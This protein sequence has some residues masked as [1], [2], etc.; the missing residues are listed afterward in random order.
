MKI[1]IVTISYNQRKYLQ[2]CIDS[3]LSQ[4]YPNLEY[5]VV[6]PGSTDGSRE[7]IASYGDRIHQIF[8]PDTGPA[9][10][11]NSGFSIAR[12]E[13]LGFINSDDTLLPGALAAVEAAFADGACDVV[14]GMGYRTNGEGIRTGQ[15]IPSR[16]TPW[17]YVHGAV[18]LFQQGTF[19]RSS[20]YHEAGGFNEDN[21]TCWDGELFL[22]MA[23]AGARFKLIHSQ[24]ATFRIH[25]ASISGSGRLIP[26]YQRDSARLFA[27]AMARPPHFTDAIVARF[28][29]LLKFA[30]DPTYLIR[31]L[32]S[33]SK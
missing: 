18:S 20:Y 27:K 26:A 7:L 32:A 31:K 12:G 15:I 2:E 1:S 13:I 24:I 14:T 28:A 22:D 5:I 10:G 19:F 17:L 30:I 4:G 11:L 8:E 6:D 33:G 29:R 3:V 21:H 9:N 23:L 16:F 25:D